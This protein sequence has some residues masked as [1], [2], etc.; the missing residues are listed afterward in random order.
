MYHDR[1]ETRY[2]TILKRK[3]LPSVQT[4]FYETLYEIC[5][6][7]EK[8]KESFFRSRRVAQ[9]NVRRKFLIYHDLVETR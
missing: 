5:I 8:K 4:L 2:P 9:E 6:E 3:G 7:I 1:V